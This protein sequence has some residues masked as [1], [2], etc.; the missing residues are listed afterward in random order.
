MRLGITA[1]MMG[2]MK[3]IK[4]TEDTIYFGQCNGKFTVVINGKAKQD[5]QNGIFMYPNG[6]I[7]Y[8]KEKV[9]LIDTNTGN[10]DK[11]TDIEDTDGIVKWGANIKK[12]N[13]ETK[14]FCQVVELIAYLKPLESIPVVS[15]TR[16]NGLIAVINGKKYLYV[17]NQKYNIINIYSNISKDNI[18]IV[19]N[20]VDYY[21]FEVDRKTIKEK[22][23]GTLNEVQG[24]I[25]TLNK[26]TIIK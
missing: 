25:K 19:A 18:I 22:L 3:A 15:L 8:H 4:G 14:N 17:N 1:V 23:K 20:N 9:Y 12:Q 10:L 7:L 6:L 26:N 11:V 24:Y 5:V 13:L 16:E 21:I 2:N